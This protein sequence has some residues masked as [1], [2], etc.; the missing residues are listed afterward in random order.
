MTR[1]V[2]FLS[3][4]LAAL[5]LLLLLLLAPGG[6]DGGSPAPASSAAVESLVVNIFQR[7]NLNGDAVLSWREA[8]VRLLRGEST[9]C[10]IPV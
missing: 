6:L 10:V 9:P 2:S 1:A 3:V 5:L 7:F 4:P 8:Q